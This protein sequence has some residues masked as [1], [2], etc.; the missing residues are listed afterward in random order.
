L[1]FLNIDNESNIEFDI[2]KDDLNGAVS[3]KK[4]VDLIDSIL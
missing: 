3:G 1:K 2:L 4:Y